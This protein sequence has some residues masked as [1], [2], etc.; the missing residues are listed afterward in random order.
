MTTRILRIDASMRHEGSTTRALADKAIAA[1]AGAGEAT[2]VTRDL[3]VTPVPQID[4]AWIG[5]NFTDEADRT[6]ADRAA[7]A[8]SD[9]LVEEIEAADWLVIATPVY[10]FG[11]PAALKAWIDQIARARRTFRYTPEGPVGLLEGKRAVIVTASGGTE[12][13]SGIDFAT[14]YLRHILGFVGITDVEVV[15]ADRTM[16]DADAAHA[17]AGRAIEALAA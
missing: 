8:L 3:A 9:R 2:V 6:A 1:I 13:G 12:V 14:P 17:R 7:L 10:N 16:V 15:A 4:E 11:V 5:A